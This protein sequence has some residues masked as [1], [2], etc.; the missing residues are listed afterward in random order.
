MTSQTPDDT[1]P[2]AITQPDPAGVSTEL[3]VVV[4]GDDDATL[5]SS[6]FLRVR[7]L[8]GRLHEAWILYPIY[9]LNLVSGLLAMSFAIGTHEW[10]APV[11]GLAWLLL[12]V[13]NWFYGV[14]Y[15][16][17]RPLLKYSS[18]IVILGLTTALVS[19]SIERAQPQLAMVRATQLSERAASAELYW[20]AVATVVAAGLLVAHLV[21]LGRGYRQKRT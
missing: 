16:Y 15:R 20:A 1:P 3:P 11:V 21:F 19:F 12:G 17:R 14:A 2:Q 8:P 18:V 9:G 6:E 13:W 4:F 10:S 5:A 7:L